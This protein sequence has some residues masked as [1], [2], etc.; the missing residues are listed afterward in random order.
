MI[1][2][3]KRQL[4][5]VFLQRNNFKVQLNKIQLAVNQK[6]VNEELMN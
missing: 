2:K 5:S 1:E 4:Y 6:E 3:K